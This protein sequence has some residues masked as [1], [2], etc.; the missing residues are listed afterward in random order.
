MA[1]TVNC[2]EEMQMVDGVI[3]CSVGGDYIALLTNKKRLCILT[4]SSASPI[5]QVKLKSLPL[6]SLFKV[7]ALG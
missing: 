2:V 6:P 4:L 7:E 5:G 1:L 3:D